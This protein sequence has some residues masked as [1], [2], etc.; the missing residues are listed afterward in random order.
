MSAP[1]ALLTRV[2][3]IEDNAAIRNMLTHALAEIGH[4]DVCAVANG[5]E[6]VERYALVNPD[7]VLL[8]WELPGISAAETLRALHT[9]NCG[10]QAPVL[11][12]SSRCTAEL[13]SSAFSAGACGT[14][15]KPLDPMIL[16]SRLRQF[17]EAAAPAR[18]V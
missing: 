13:E 5:E 17:Y 8:D 16:A 2:M 1:S 11:V 9:Q 3:C 14:L 6:A 12:M 7:L 18:V 10:R 4:L 15:K